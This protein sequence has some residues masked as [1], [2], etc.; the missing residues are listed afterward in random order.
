[1]INCKVLEKR[2]ADTDV[3]VS[4]SGRKREWGKKEER[5]E[6]KERGKGRKEEMR[7]QR[8]KGKRGP[9]SNTSAFNKVHQSTSPTFIQ[10]V[11]KELLSATLLNIDK[12]LGGQTFEKSFQNEDL[13][14]M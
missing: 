10:R 11:S 1:M 3:R 13:T 9:F 12:R 6:R 14:K 2:S 7:K 8:K 4:Q 5:E